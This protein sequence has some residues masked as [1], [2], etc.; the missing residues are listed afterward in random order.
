MATPDYSETTYA[1]LLLS[2][3]QTKHGGGPIYPTFLT[4]QQEGAPG[5]GYDGTVDLSGAIHFLQF[6]RSHVMSYVTAQELASGDFS[7]PPV[8]RM[9]LR[10]KNSY[11]QHT[12]LNDL[13]SQGNS[14]LYASSGASCQDQ[15]KTQCQIQTVVN[16]SGF[17]RPSEI[18]FPL[19]SEQHFVSF[20][21]SSPYFHT[22]SQE[23]RRAKRQIPDEEALLR[24]SAERRRTKRQNLAA[25]KSF[26][27]DLVP[28]VFP[29]QP[30]SIVQ[31]AALWARMRYDCELIILPD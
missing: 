15:L 1:F 3:L 10:K 27:G 29:G 30:E 25:L 19:D 13:E 7:G 11:Y 5:G 20:V 4:Q 23:G 17:F 22:Y 12:Q 16:N 26:V 28:S 31:R 24:Y 14:V 21:P 2:E 18:T 8:F 9:N 6:K